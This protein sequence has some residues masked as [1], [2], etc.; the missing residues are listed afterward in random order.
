MT[1]KTD[2]SDQCVVCACS[3]LTKLY[4]GCAE[5]V[6]LRLCEQ[7]AANGGCILCRLCGER[8]RANEQRSE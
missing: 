2:D 1:L 7:C 8:M 6:R 4:E 3:T 5:S